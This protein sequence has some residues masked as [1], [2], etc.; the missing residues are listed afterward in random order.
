MW[1]KKCLFS[2]PQPLVC[3]VVVGPSIVSTN[4]RLPA[5][6]LVGESQVLLIF[7]I[8]MFPESPWHKAPTFSK[9]EKIQDKGAISQNKAAT[10]YLNFYRGL[11]HHKRFTILAIQISY[12]KYLFVYTD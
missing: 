2:Y 8:D 11:P 3:I 10:K 4:C 5:D 12:I 7:G 6:H 9:G 1:Q